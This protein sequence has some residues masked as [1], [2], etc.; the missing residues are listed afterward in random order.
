ME[1]ELFILPC[2][3]TPL[4]SYSCTRTLP[5]VAA[6]FDYSLLTLVFM[7]GFRFRQQDFPTADHLVR[8]FQKH[9]NDDVTQ[10]R[11]RGAMAA[12]AAAAAA[13][14]ALQVSANISSRSHSTQP[15]APSSRGGWDVQP[16]TAG[17]GVGATAGSGRSAAASWAPQIVH[18]SS[19]PVP[20]GM[21]WSGGQWRT[22]PGPR[23]GAG[24]GGAYGG[25][26]REYS[27][28]PAAY[29]A[30]GQPRAQRWDAG[31]PGGSGMPAGGAGGGAAGGQGQARGA[32]Q[33]GWGQGSWSSGPGKQGGGEGQPGWPVPA[34]GRTYSNNQPQ[35]Q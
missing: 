35:W 8:Y 10:A 21:T 20:A 12:S 11:Q 3:R 4:R 32:P 28:A 18:V 24:A 13:A 25:G 5:I 34:T 33:A 26:G 17:T 16:V 2:V 1:S 6:P 7:Q 29:P 27:G 19:T 30:A 31:G 9:V 22:E 23:G 14:S 15:G